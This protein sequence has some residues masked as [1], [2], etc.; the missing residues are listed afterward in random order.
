MGLRFVVFSLCMLSAGTVALFEADWPVAMPFL[1]LAVAVPIV[2]RTVGLKELVRYD[3][4]RG[5]PRRVRVAVYALVTLVSVLVSA[6]L[7]AWAFG[8]SNP[9]IAFAPLYLVLTVY[10]AWAV[11][12]VRARSR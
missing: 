9:V 1:W 12:H 10:T 2:E 8:A 5:S 7:A 3:P 6:A 11:V 4:W